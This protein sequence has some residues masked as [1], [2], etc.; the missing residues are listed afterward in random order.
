MLKHHRRGDKGLSLRHRRRLRGFRPG[1][2][3]LVVSG[4]LLCQRRLP[5]EN[6]FWYVKAGIRA[7]FILCK[8]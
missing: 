7:T 4:V 8:P 2:H 1:I 3:P 6:S 5:K